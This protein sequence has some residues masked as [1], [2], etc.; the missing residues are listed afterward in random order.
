[1][2]SERALEMGGGTR[3][4]CE[5]QR[6][7]ADHAEGQKSPLVVN[8]QQDHRENSDGDHARHC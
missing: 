6:N 7:A 8:P 1:V 4:H 2:S 3:S 5:Q